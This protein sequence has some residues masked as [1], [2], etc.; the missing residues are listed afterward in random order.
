MPDLSFFKSAT[1]LS[2]FARNPLESTF[3]LFAASNNSSKALSITAKDLKSEKSRPPFSERILIFSLDNSGCSFI[4]RS[5]FFSLDF[6]EKDKSFTFPINLS[7]SSMTFFTMF[8]TTFPSFA[9]TFVFSLLIF[10]SFF[11]VK[12]PVISDSNKKGATALSYS[13]LMFAN[14]TAIDCI[15]LSNTNTGSV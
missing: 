6:K 1:N 7:A 12:I 13:V 4:K 2:Y 5:I 9:K 14:V 10:S 11:S 3:G 15:S 8:F